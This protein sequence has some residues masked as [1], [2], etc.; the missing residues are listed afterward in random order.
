MFRF[1]LNVSV[2]EMHFEKKPPKKKYKD[3]RCNKDA[4]LPSNGMTDVSC[5]VGLRAHGRFGEANLV[6]F[7][8]IPSGCLDLP[9]LIGLSV[10]DDALLDVIGVNQVLPSLVIEVEHG[11]MFFDS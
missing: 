8:A 7:L 3:M 4:E 6:S 10:G 5:C 9:Y 2:S 11:L 1:S